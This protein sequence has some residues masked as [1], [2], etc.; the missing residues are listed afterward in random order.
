MPASQENNNAFK[1]MLDK[2]PLKEVMGIL[3]FND[4]RSVVKWCKNK[5]VII[6]KFGKEM[7]VNMAEF[8][9]AMDQPLI[10]SLKTKYPDRWKE[11]YAAY[12]KGDLASIAELMIETV[13]D[14]KN[15]AF[16]A[17]GKSGT[18]FLNKIIKNKK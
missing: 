2:I 5:S 7:Y 1:I 3:R 6:L 4:I 17:P 16:V 18:N 10:E 12:K 8:E 15:V 14:K 11:M 13:S 9:V